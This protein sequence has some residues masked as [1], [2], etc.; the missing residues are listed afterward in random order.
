MPFTLTKNDQS[1]IDSVV[2]EYSKEPPPVSGFGEGS[3]SSN[4]IEFQF[5]P[6]VLSDTKSS[7]WEHEPFFTFEPVSIYVGSEPRAIQI[8]AEYI[9]TNSGGWTVDKVINMTHRAKSYF[10]RGFKSAGSTNFNKLPVVF[11]TIYGHAFG[12]NP[13]SSWRVMGINISHGEEIFSDPIG[14]KLKFP[15]YTKII[16]DLKLI[17]KIGFN[18]KDAK[19]DIEGLPLK[20]LF[21]WY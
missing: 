1:I 3:D 21:N 4:K 18:Q 10:Y 13:K 9:I 14:N 11:L 7:N 17:T 20:P 19:Q 12:G 5:P 8:Q 6:K 16:W 15:I 2:F